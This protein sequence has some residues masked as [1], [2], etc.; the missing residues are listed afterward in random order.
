M[1][2]QQGK[3]IAGVVVLYHPKESIHANIQ[4][5]G[6]SLDL[7]VVVDNT[8]E[9]LPWVRERISGF[10]NAVY[11]ANSANLGIAV[12]QN[13]GARFAL[14]KGMRW[15]LTMD[16]DSSFEGDAFR[17]LAKAA[18][19]HPGFG[20]LSAR[21]ALEGGRSDSPANGVEEIRTAMASGNLLNLTAYQDAGPFREDYF[22]DYVDHEYCLRL[23]R[24]GYRILRV[25][26]ARLNHSLGNLVTVNRFG[27]RF[28]PTHHSPI[29]RYYMTRNRLAMLRRYPEALAPEAFA[30]SKEMV[31]LLLFE[32][33]K[34]R[35]LRYIALGFWH[36]LTGKR[37]SLDGQG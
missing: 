18:E 22:I 6:P 28:R 19:R 33:E 3:G 12:A 26:S 15:L 32:D 36:F 31:K 25:N 11:I 16:Q 8:P 30:W 1:A 17:L 37:G 29:R 2:A 24:K 34:A 27:L 14:E 5:Y 7:L 23:R 13:Q 21:H 35:K 20:I 4:S 10:N 9:P